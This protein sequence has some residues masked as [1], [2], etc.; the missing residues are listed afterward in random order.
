MTASVLALVALVGAV[1]VLRGRRPETRLTGAAEAHGRVI[2]PLVATVR[3]LVRRRS[4]GD[5]PLVGALVDAWA[6]QL[7]AG[8][9]VSAALEDAFDDVRG[10]R[11][12]LPRTAVALSVGGEVG[13]AIRLDAAATGADVRRSLSAAAACWSVAQ[14]NG[15]RMA[16]ALDR[17]GDGIRADAQHTA[18]VRAQLAGPRA[19]ARLLAALPLFALVLGSGLGLRPVAVLLGEPV[20]RAVL[21]G[22]VALDVAGLWWTER[23]ARAAERAG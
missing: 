13:A 1:T 3:R 5:A 21:V 10:A 2:S 22:G 9:P 7:R 14:D 16:E 6:A 19:T 11:T 8:R 4:Q 18:H 23:M 20:G 15:G 12:V 17:L